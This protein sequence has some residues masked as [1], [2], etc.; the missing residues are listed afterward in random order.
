MCVWMSKKLFFLVTWSISWFLNELFK[1]LWN[2]YHDPFQRMKKIVQDNVF[3]GNEWLGMNRDFADTTRE[4]E[5]SI[6]FLPLCRFH[7]WVSLFWC[8]ERLKGQEDAFIRFRLVFRRDTENEES[9]AE[10]Q[11]WYCTICYLQWICLGLLK[12]STYRTNLCVNDNLPECRWLLENH[13]E[14]HITPNSFFPLR[15]S[16]QSGFL[17]FFLHSDY[18]TDECVNDYSTR[19]RREN[20]NSN[21]SD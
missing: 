12:L 21:V 7:G 5:R 14:V 10:V 9:V 1:K 20:D 18:G 6:F 4:R 2:F 11:H 19:C 16:H 15:L 8:T 13:S 17:V 3:V